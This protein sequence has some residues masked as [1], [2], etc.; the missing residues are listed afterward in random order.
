MLTFTQFDDGPMEMI[1][2]PES[3]QEFSVDLFGSPYIAR[4]NNVITLSDDA[5]RLIRYRI[6]GD[7]RD[8][9][10]VTAELIED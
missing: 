8:G 6:T 10:V 4:A 2:E 7:R 9:H 5:G 3:T 1:G